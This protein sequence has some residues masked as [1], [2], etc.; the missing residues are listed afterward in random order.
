M[1]TISEYQKLIHEIFL[2]SEEENDRWEYLDIIL[3]Y[4]DLNSEDEE[5]IKELDK[6]FFVKTTKE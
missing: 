5:Y 1:L 2:L 4:V 6:Q 3:K